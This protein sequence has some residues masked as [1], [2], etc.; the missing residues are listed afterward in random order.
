MSAADHV[1]RFRLMSTEELLAKK[2][3]LE[4]Q[5]SIFQSQ[6]VGTKTSVRD[7]RFLA[8]QLNAVAQV[9]A[10]RGAQTVIK[11]P[12]NNAIGVADFSQVP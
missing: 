9:L 2:A 12:F 8:E 7:L 10:E 5:D 4:E 11:A 3:K 6:T 1:L